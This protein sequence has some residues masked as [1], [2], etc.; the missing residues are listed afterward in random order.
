[1][2]ADETVSVSIAVC[3]HCVLEFLQPHAAYKKVCR[4]LFCV[5]CSAK[6]DSV[7]VRRA[8]A[9]PGAVGHHR[10]ANSGTGLLRRHL[11]L[12]HRTT[13][14]RRNH[15]PPSSAMRGATL[16]TSRASQSDSNGRSTFRLLL[17]L[18]KQSSSETDGELFPCASSVT[19]GHRPAGV[20]PRSLSR[21]LAHYAVGIRPFVGVEISCVQVVVLD[22]HTYVS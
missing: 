15:S 17:T 21:R 19:Q 22:T 18:A 13:H 2:G 20:K 8:K 9:K 6:S 11:S 16:K 4:S 5:S 10:G 14:V 12:R 3:L 7:A 1:M